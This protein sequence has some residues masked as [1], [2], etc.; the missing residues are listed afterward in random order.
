MKLDLTSHHVAL[1]GEDALHI[2]RYRPCLDPI[3]RA[4]LGEPVRF[5]AANHVLAG[6]AGDVR[7]R[8][9]DVL[10]LHH[11]RAVARL[12]QGPRQVLAGL[13]TADNEDLVAFDLGHHPPP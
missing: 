5:R 7:T 6:Q 13:S 11:R 8:S 10:T 1:A 2:R 4:V 3:F 12:R 9:A